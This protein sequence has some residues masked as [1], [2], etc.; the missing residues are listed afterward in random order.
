MVFIVFREESE[1]TG[2]RRFDIRNLHIRIYL[3][4]FRLPS[5]LLSPHVAGGGCSAIWVANLEFPKSRK[6]SNPE[7]VSKG[8]EL[9]ESHWTSPLGPLAC[10]VGWAL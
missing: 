2:S 5:D 4:A 8:L 3:P 7:L 6:N 9:P 1:R 10:V